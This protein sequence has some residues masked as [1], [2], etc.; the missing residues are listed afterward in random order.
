MTSSES[1]PAISFENEALGEV[2]KSLHKDLSSLL[3]TLFRGEC[4]HHVVFDCTNDLQASRFHAEDG[5]Q[6]EWM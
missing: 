6:L 4:A 2:T 3:G 5:F 1:Y